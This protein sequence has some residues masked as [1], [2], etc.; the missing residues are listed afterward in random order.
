V[1]LVGAVA[2]AD[3]ARV[4]AGVAGTGAEKLLGRGDFLLVAK[5]DVVRFQAAYAG[6]ADIAEQV[7]RLRRPGP[8]LLTEGSKNP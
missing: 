1:R 5:G 4:A 8:P 7:A 6:E 3:D 2:S